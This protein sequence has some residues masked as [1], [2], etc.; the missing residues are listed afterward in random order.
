LFKSTDPVSVKY[1]KGQKTRG[2]GSDI[3]FLP[4]SKKK[5]LQTYEVEAPDASLL[6]CEVTV[7]A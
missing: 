2:A 1:Y 7:E 5:F 6:A 3:P 4:V